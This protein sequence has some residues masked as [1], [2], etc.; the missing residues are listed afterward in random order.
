MRSHLFTIPMAKEANVEARINRIL[1]RSRVLPKS[2]GGAAWL[3]LIAVA[4]PLIYFVAAI[5][6]APAQTLMQI[7][8]PHAPDAPALVAQAQRPE[9]PP[10]TPPSIQQPHASDVSSPDAADSQ[11]VVSFSPVR[12]G[13]ITMPLG[14]PG[15]YEI[16]FRI[17]TEERKLVTSGY[18]DVAGSQFEVPI[19]L[20]AGNYR[21]DLIFRDLVK[22]KN[23]H[24][25][26]EF[27]VK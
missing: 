9:S 3:A 5:Q 27:E 21:L 6:L 23:V 24:R 14:A 13:T 2:F 16:Y 11:P 17:T 7:P 22:Q 4:V 15:E 10:P 19:E 18:R 26:I 25:Q 20:E 8:V 1:D 12:R